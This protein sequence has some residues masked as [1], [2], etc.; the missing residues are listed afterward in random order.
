MYNRY[1]YQIIDRLTILI[2]FDYEFPYLYL[3]YNKL[4]S[5]ITSEILAESV[6][7]NIRLPNW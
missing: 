1:F 2:F 5:V 7:T 4:S 6:I 3:I